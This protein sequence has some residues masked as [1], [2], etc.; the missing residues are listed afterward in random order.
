MKAHPQ[1]FICRK[2]QK[3]HAKVFRHP[4][5]EYI[6]VGNRRLSSSV[7]STIP[8]LFLEFSLHYFGKHTLTHMSFETS[9]AILVRNLSVWGSIFAD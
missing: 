1:N 5:S 2:S 7:A 3:I 8:F 4:Q 6:V 9:S